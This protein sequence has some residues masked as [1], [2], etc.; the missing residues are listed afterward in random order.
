[1]SKSTKLSHATINDITGYLA[2]I[3]LNGLTKCGTQPYNYASV[4][5]REKRRMCYIYKNT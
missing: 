3:L 2:N 4:I 5:F 1:M